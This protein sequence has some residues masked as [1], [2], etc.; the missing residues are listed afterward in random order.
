M[1]IGIGVLASEGN[2][3][4]PNTLVLLADTKGS[5]GES[6][7]MNRLH[8]IFIAPDKNLFAVGAGQMD[9]AA[10]LFEVI[11]DI[12]QIIPGGTDRYGS[13]VETVG[14]AA[15]LLLRAQSS[16]QIRAIEARGALAYWGAWRDL[17][18]NFPRNDLPRVPDHWQ[19]FGSRSP[20]FW[21]V[22]RCQSVGRY[23]N[24]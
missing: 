9:E 14:G 7:S 12:S 13:L 3:I 23:S 4:K 18:I 16:D 6:Y 20:E 22:F 24:R 11:R 2:G 21:T 8:K 15:D 17:S 1:S 10:E 5:F 19:K